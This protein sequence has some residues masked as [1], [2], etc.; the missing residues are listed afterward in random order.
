LTIPPLSNTPQNGTLATEVAANSGCI[1]IVEGLTPTGRPDQP[2]LLCSAPSCAG[3]SKLALFNL[4]DGDR[5]PTID[6][7][8][9]G[10]SSGGAESNCNRSPSSFPSA[11]SPRSGEHIPRIPRGSSNPP[12]TTFV[13]ASGRTAMTLPDAVSL[14]PLPGESC[15][16]TPTGGSPTATLS[17]FATM[18]NEDAFAQN[19]MAEQLTPI[20]QEL[21]LM[22]LLTAAAAW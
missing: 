20:F 1:K 12:F 21:N 4:P 19:R 14:K 5:T 7:S 11:G 15:R 9:T 3:P 2:L 6:T 16:S 13:T 8:R 10:S 22:Q 17:P 18:I